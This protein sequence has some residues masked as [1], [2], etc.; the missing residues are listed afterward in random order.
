M[1]PFYGWGSTSSRLKSHYEEAVYF[2]PPHPQKFLVH[3]WSTL[4]GWKAKLTLEPLSGLNMGPLDWKFSILTTRPNNW[5]KD[6][7]LKNLEKKTKINWKK[8]YCTLFNKSKTASKKKKFS[9]ESR[10]MSCRLPYTSQNT[11]AEVFYR[12]D[13]L[14]IKKIGNTPVVE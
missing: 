8:I 3:L 9:H 1:N 5:R 4:E 11:D 14:K 6:W 10:D 13:V 2:L 7:R 12:L